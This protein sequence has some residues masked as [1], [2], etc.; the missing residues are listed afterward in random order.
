MNDI[1]LL[2]CTFIVLSIH[3]REEKKRNDGPSLALPRSTFAEVRLILYRWEHCWMMKW[4]R[5]KDHVLE[6]KVAREVNFSKI[7][8]NHSSI[9]NFQ[10]SRTSKSRNS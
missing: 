5:L 4:A 7:L 8:R 10:F 2:I 3:R 6:P 9:S 1:L